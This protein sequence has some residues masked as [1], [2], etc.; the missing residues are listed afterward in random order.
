MR[1]PIEQNIKRA[2]SIRNFAW[3][4]GAIIFLYGLYK[5]FGQ[6]NE[7]Q[8]DSSIGQALGFMAI[9]LLSFVSP[10]WIGLVTEISLEKDQ[11][12][13]EH[14]NKKQITLGYHEVSDIYSIK[15]GS[16][17]Y[18][19]FESEKLKRSIVVP[20][21]DVLITELESKEDIKITSLG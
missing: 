17:T 6:F 5:L 9:G 8:T 19:S 7:N 13:F 12:L 3:L 21:N 18:L 14:S 11:L 10:T 4:I 15:Q 1:I 2:R 16:S 20:G